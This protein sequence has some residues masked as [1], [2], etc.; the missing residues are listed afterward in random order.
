MVILR[1]CSTKPNFEICDTGAYEIR[2]RPLFC[3]HPHPELSSRD[4]RNLSEEHEMRIFHQFGESTDTGCQRQR[5]T[6]FSEFCEVCRRR[7]Q[8]QQRASWIRDGEKQN[9]GFVFCS[10]VLHRWNWKHLSVVVICYGLTVI[11]STS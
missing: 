5:V 7:L 1:M 8:Q 3:G 11:V 9:F 10:G 2:K 4:L 6:S